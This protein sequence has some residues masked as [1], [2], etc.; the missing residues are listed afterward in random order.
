MLPGVP[1]S[2]PNSPY[3]KN[4]L[5]LLSLKSDIFVCKDIPDQFSS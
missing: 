3:R 4:H 2:S 5:N 1:N